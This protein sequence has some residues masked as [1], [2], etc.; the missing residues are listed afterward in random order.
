MHFVILGGSGRNGSLVIKQALANNHTI[1]ALVRKTSSL[2]PHP[3]LTLVQ[4]SPLS[5]ADIKTALQTPFAPDAVFM[6]LSQSRMKDSPFAALNPD[7]PTDFLEQVTVLLL[8]SIKSLQ[9][10]PKLV[11]NSTQ[12]AGS[13]AGSLSWAVNFIFSHSNMKYS[14]EDHDHVD[15]LVRESRL[16]FA[17]AR[18][19]RLVEAIDGKAS[20]IKD[21]GDQ[22]K[23]AGLMAKCER[24]AVAEWMVSAAESDTWNG[25]SPV[26]VTE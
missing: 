19:A 15:V 9:I 8:S 7:V 23:G 12:G 3:N 13:S 2:T 10:R 26:L 6:T 20:P 24:E 22:G 16:D 25:R 17:I 11:F 1:T 5:E 18:P 14:R 21:L 4:G